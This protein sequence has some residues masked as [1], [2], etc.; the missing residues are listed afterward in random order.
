MPFHL[1]V[2]LLGIEPKK[3]AY[4]WGRYFYQYY[5]IT[6]DFQAMEIVLEII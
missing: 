4:E 5:L 3:I 2:P 1:D 6:K